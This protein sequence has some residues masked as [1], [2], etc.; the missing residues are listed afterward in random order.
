MA[1]TRTRRS[2]LERRCVSKS[3]KRLFK[4]DGKTMFKVIYGAECHARNRKALG[5]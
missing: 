1:I 5:A 4:G 3:S 2:S